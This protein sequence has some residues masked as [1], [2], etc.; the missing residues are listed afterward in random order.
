M[1]HILN[2]IKKYWFIFAIIILYFLLAGLNFLPDP[3]NIFRKKKLEIN[4]TPVVVQKIKEIG[5]LT[6][7]EFYGEVYADINEV[8]DDLIAL[9]KDSLLAHSALFYKDYSGLK[10]YMQKFGE[11]TDREKEYNQERKR[12]KNMLNDY[13]LKVSEFE[14]SEANIIQQLSKTNGRKKKRKLNKQLESI[15]K[16]IEQSK[17]ELADASGRFEKIENQYRQK[18]FAYWESRKAR[19]LVYIGR[20]WVKAG[21]NLQSISEN[22]IVI[23][24]NEESSIQILL[25]NPVILN[26]DINPWFIY[27]KEKQVRGFE[28]FLEKTGSIFTNNNFTDKE[29]KELKHKC[30]DKLME[31][32]IEKG[33][34]RNA[35]KSAAKTIENFFRLIGFEH[36]D[37]K[38]KSDKQIADNG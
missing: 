8:Y 7:A 5:E 24:S 26:A 30:K 13:I 36:V 12:Y 22:D 11:Q 10:V 33:L 18:R 1:T 37:I 38:F 9:H 28:V 32:G 34:L 15:R 25:P 14:E 3:L 31:V 16:N 20:G 2:F 35:R 29:V 17:K 6:T 27:T 19:N 21:I 4:D 23:N